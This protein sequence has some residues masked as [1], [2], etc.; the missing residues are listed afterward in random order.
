MH[1]WTHEIRQAIRLLGRDWAFTAAV[2]ATLALGIG[3]NAAIFTL[4]DQLLLRQLPVHE[5]SRLVIL[6]APGPNQGSMHRFSAFSTPISYPMYRDLRDGTGEV[7]E[8]LLARVPATVNV[9]TG[10]TEATDAELVS[11]NYF[12]VLG[13]RAAHGRLLTQDDDR[14]RLGHPVVVLSQAYWQRR[15]GADPRVVGRKLDVNKQLFEIVGVAEAGFH[16]VEVGRVAAL[17]LPMAMKPWVT[18]TWDDLEARRVMWLNPVA[19]LRRGVSVERAAVVANT[20]YQRILADEVKTI[21]VPPEH[22]ASFVPAFVGKRLT[23]LPGARGGSDLRGSFS[24][25][26]LVLMGMVGFVLLIACANVA[27]LLAA[28]AAARQRELAVRVALG[29][30]RG[31]LVRQLVAEGLA[32]ALVGGLLGLACAYWT[33]DALLLALGIDPATSALSAGPDARVLLFTLLV[34][35]GA[36]LLSSLTPA[37][38]ASRVAIAQCLREEAGSVAGS[39]A[40]ARLRSSLVVLEVALSLLLL[41]GA[42]LFARTLGNLQ[43]VN[44]GFDTRAL[45]TFSLDPSLAGYDTARTRDLILRLRDQVAALPGV[46][47]ASAADVAVL[48]DSSSRTSVWVPG[49]QERPG[50][51]A[52]AEVNFVT[53][54][55]FATLG[56]GL[57]RGRPIDARD[58][59]GAAP[60]AVVNQAFVKQFFGEREALG[61]RFGFGRE[62]DTPLEIVGVVQDGRL[63]SLRDELRPAIYLPRAQQGD[64]AGGN[65]TFYL[66]TST[67]PALLAG[68]VRAL[69]RGVDTRLPV[70]D[71]RTMTEVVERSL[72]LE[73]LT[74]GLSMAFGLLATL[75]AAIGLY[76]VLAFGVARRTREIGVRMALGAERGAVVGLVLRDV[77]RLAGLGLGLGLPAAVMLGRIVESQLFGLRAADPLTL[78]GAVLLL[79]TI[80]TLAGYLP[81]RQAVRVDPMRALR[82]E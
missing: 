65:V 50:E 2:V 21:E 14:Q 10:E 18:P 78:L 7:F 31:R 42:G 15:F 47:S 33:T 59:D 75:L 40:Q 16:G 9:T 61:G 4:L 77:L 79:A 37:L 17:F 22:R 67:A 58:R 54:E 43:S 71:L 23:F 34:S 60:V 72:V 41:V 70:N 53:A 12:D 81:A 30:S 66:R 63:R 82:T 25:Q 51:R 27:N 44:P 55:H 5:P 11:G 73:R 3:A 19:R 38:Q 57:L 28:R 13:V 64:D 80:V 8:G 36:C 52:I 29:A 39:R 48:T 69:V 26:L 49:Y 20:V 35:L 32:L 1:T 76:A 62:G 6:D 45:L 68:A 46:V 56:I 24:T 74:A